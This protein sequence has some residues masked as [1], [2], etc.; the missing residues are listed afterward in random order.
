MMGGST[1]EDPFCMRALR[2]HE[3]ETNLVS[4]CLLRRVCVAMSNEYETIAFVIFGLFISNGV[5][6]SFLQVSQQ[7]HLTS[8]PA[9]QASST[10][11]STPSLPDTERPTRL[12]AC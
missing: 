5:I 4:H 9:S 7:G 6:F 11:A 8:A 10:N 12:S 2:H 3:T 1:I